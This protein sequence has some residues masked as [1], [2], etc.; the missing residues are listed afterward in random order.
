[1]SRGHQPHH[2]GGGVAGYPA[3]SSVSC[4]IQC[5]SIGLKFRMSNADAVS[6]ACCA[7][8]VLHHGVTVPCDSLSKKNTI[9]CTNANAHA[10]IRMSDSEV[11]EYDKSPLRLSPRSTSME[12]RLEVFGPKCHKRRRERPLHGYNFSPPSTPI[13]NHFI[14]PVK[15]DV[16]KE[17]ESAAFTPRC[18]LSKC[19]AEQ[20]TLVQEAGINPTDADWIMM[21]SYLSPAKPPVHPMTKSIIQYLCRF[22]CPSKSG[23]VLCLCI[24]CAGVKAEPKCTPCLVCGAPIPY[25]VCIKNLGV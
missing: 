23:V 15:L 16:K 18:V 10:S 22:E 2:R 25:S 3:E 17:D 7:A 6:C 21:A 1:M 9:A 11:E 19:I 5:S 4:V 20:E 24:K 13:G 8:A 14:A 12:F